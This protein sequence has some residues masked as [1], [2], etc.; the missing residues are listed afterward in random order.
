MI[1]AYL[2]PR[3]PRAP[4]TQRVR[5]ADMAVAIASALAALFLV[6]GSTQGW[7]PGGGA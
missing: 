2:R 1:R 7:L 5:L 4:R 3:N 6:I